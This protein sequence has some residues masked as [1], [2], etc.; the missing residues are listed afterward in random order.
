MRQIHPIASYMA[1]IGLKEEMRIVK[2]QYL[3]IVYVASQVEGLLCNETYL[4]AS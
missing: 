2:S 4:I 1:S 3:Q